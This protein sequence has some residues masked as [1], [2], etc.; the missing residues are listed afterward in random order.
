[1][2]FYLGGMN[3]SVNNI[4]DVYVQSARGIF[5]LNTLL[6]TLSEKDC[7][8]KMEPEVREFLQRIVKTISL[9]LLWLLINTIAGLK[10]E[11][12]IIDGTHIVGTIIFF[13]WLFISGYF[14]LRV[15]KLW[16]KGHFWGLNYFTTF[17][18]RIGSSSFLMAIQYIPLGSFSEGIGIRSFPLKLP[19]LFWYKTLPFVS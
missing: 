1:M 6:W 16:W 14:L 4:F 8:F 17:R 19:I 18:T 9:A 12:V 2:D 15:Y 5:L 11:L 13:L 7:F 3:F 10:F